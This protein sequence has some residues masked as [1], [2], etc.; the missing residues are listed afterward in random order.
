M[1][2][3]T[4]RIATPDDA[5]AISQLVLNLQARFTFHEYTEDGKALMARELAP[6][7]IADTIG[8]GDVVFLAEQGS[9]LVGVVSIRENEHLSLNFVDENF[10]KRGISSV[11]WALGREECIK[12]GNVGR[13]TLRAST[14]AIPVYEKWGFVLTGEINRSG[15][16]LSYPMVLEG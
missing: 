6:A 13:F 8:R 9:R 5:G 2:G 1:Q 3:I 12:R 4:F 15:G 11:L 14:F 10:H 7:K 16:I